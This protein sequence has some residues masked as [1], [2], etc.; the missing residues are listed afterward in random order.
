MKYSMVLFELGIQRLTNTALACKG[1]ILID[2]ST[3]TNVII[4]VMFR[5]KSHSIF[6]DHY[7]SIY[8]NVYKIL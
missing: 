4:K 8:S 3:I 2:I 6:L 1:S 7:Y 5:C